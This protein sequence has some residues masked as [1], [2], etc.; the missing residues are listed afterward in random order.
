MQDLFGSA[1][2]YGCNRLRTQQFSKEFLEFS[3]PHM[4]CICLFCM[5]CISCIT[6][7]IRMTFSVWLL[8]TLMT[9]WLLE[10]HKKNNQILHC[11]AKRNKRQGKLF[12]LTLLPSNL[13]INRN[14]PHDILWHSFLV[15]FSPRVR[16]F[17]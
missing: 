2:C 1:K 9:K 14:S 10:E 11:M 4:H 16:D 3:K 17:K 8:H 5:H 7:L 15:N 12:H 13:G 6:A